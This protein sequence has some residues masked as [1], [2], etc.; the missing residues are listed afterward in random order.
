MQENQIKAHRQGIAS[1]E[2]MWSLR[3]FGVFVTSQDSSWTNEQFPTFRFVLVTC[4]AEWFSF[5]T[6][7]KNSSTCRRDTNY[8]WYKKKSQTELF[9]VFLSREV[10]SSGIPTTTR[11]TFSCIAD[12]WF[13]SERNFRRDIFHSTCHLFWGKVLN[14]NSDNKNRN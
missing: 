13:I 9:T 2:N 11:N 8:I 3:R 6:T 7:W 10:C 1:K 4:G 12:D 5:S 14:E